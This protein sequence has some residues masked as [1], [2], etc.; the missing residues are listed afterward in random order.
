MHSGREAHDKL[1]TTLETF[2]NYNI[3]ESRSLEV[4]AAMREHVLSDDGNLTLW[5]GQSAKCLH[6]QDSLSAAGRHFGE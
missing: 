1:F 3:S 2:Q 5:G 4:S 6:S